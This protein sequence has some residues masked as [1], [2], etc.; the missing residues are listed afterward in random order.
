MTRVADFVDVPQMNPSQLKAAIERS[1]VALAIQASSL[2]FMHYAGG[3]ITDSSCGT[4][5]NHGVLAVGYGIENGLEYFLVK[6][7]WGETWGD[8]GYVK[9]GVEEGEGVCGIQI[10]PIQAE[11]IH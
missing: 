6:N 9:I 8:K 7:S 3:V 10:A 2:V 5:I 11:N 1:P 4:K